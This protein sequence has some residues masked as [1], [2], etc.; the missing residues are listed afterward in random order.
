MKSKFLWGGI[1]LLWGAV[2]IFAGGIWFL[3]KSLISETECPLPWEKAVE[4]FPLAVGKVPGWTVRT[5]PCGLPIPEKGSR[6]MVFELCSRK[7]AG[8]ILMDAGARKTAAVLP[9]KIAIYE[10]GEKTYI[11]RLNAPVFMRLL[12]GTPA[13]VFADGILPE[14]NVMLRKLISKP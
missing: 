5:V 6:I 14:Q 1:G 9:C 8:E 2:L 7:Y 11:A 13:E 12:G 10:R 3:R 4:Q